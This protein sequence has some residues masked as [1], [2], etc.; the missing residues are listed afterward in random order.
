LEIGQTVLRKW[1]YNGALYN[2]KIRLCSLESNSNNQKLEQISSIQ[3]LKISDDHENDIKTGPELIEQNEENVKKI[4][5]L[6]EKLADR[7][8]ELIDT[9]M[10]LDQIKITKNNL[11]SKCSKLESELTIL[12]EQC[13]ILAAQRNQYEAILDLDE[14]FNR[15]GDQGPNDNTKYK[16][17]QKMKKLEVKMKT[18]VNFKSGD[19]DLVAEKIRLA[20]LVIDGIKLKPNEKRPLVD[21]IEKR[22]FM[23]QLEL[24]KR[25]ERD[26]SQLSL[27]KLYD[28]QTDSVANASA[29]RQKIAEIK[30]AAK[31]QK[32]RSDRYEY[33]SPKLPRLSKY[34]TPKKRKQDQII[35]GESGIASKINR[36]ESDESSSDTRS[37]D[38]QLPRLVPGPVE[39]EDETEEDAYQVQLEANLEILDQETDSKKRKQALIGLDTIV[40]N[41]KNVEL[42]EKVVSACIKFCD[43]NSNSGL[44]LTLKKVISI[45]GLDT[46]ALEKLRNKAINVALKSMLSNNL[47]NTL[48]SNP[49]G[50]LIIM[51]LC[52]KLIRTENYRSMGFSLMVAVQDEMQTWDTDELEKLES[53][54]EKRPC[55]DLDLSLGL[56][57]FLSTIGPINDFFVKSQF[58]Q[59]KLNS[60]LN[61]DKTVSHFSISDT[62]EIFV[63]KIF[64]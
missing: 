35:D 14:N 49:A 11:E 58:K 40:S 42:L 24:V 52:M 15:K 23:E 60:T 34:L 18:E 17:L 4:Q 25:L 43:V 26:R 2:C 50:I 20:S 33:S 30:N 3:K 57:I 7:D 62:G 39:A 31:T 38:S 64:F 55:L 22:R 12:K 27:I 6:E 61:F 32:S 48:L 37:I 46:P 9:K 47:F 56:G 41:V 21:N 53:V 36:R 28:T 19:F 63:Q 44:F 45:S 51:T 1:P 5:A 29:T 54:I 10:S 16:L 59:I 8:K 13:A